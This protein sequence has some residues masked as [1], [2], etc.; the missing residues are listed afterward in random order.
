[1]VSMANAAGWVTAQVGETPLFSGPPG[2]VKTE[3]AKAFIRWAGRRPFC[4][5][6]SIIAA[7]AVGG[8]PGVVEVDGKRYCEM[9]PLDWAM[10]THEQPS[11]LIIDEL[12]TSPPPVQAAMLRIICERKIGNFDLPAD[13]WIIS[14][15]NPP[16]CAANGFELEPPMANRLGHYTWK[17][18]WD[19]VMAG[20][21]NGL[22]FPDL[23]YPKVPENWMDYQPA[24]GNLCAA[25]RER[26][27]ELFEPATDSSGNMK[28]SDSE[29]G[30]A[31]GTARSWTALQKVWSGLEAVGLGDEEKFE[32]GA[33]YV[34]VDSAAEFVTYCK[35]L[36][37]PDPEAWLTRFHDDP[38]ADFTPLDRPDLTIAF[39]GSLEYAVREN[40]TK[41]RW[42]A[43]M[44]LLNNLVTKPGQKV[45]VHEAARALHGNDRDG[46][47]IVKDNYTMPA[48]LGQELQSL[49]RARL[50]VKDRS[51][52]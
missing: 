8:Y 28:L 12:T 40:N 27:P 29:Q 43:A 36:D 11:A 31:Y 1:M 2:S 23:E 35:E 14:M 42:E 37:L 24:I 6:G 21:R 16:G 30:G 33:A 32:A 39:L 46:N 49:L 44:A 48:Q 34:G 51:Q 3:V 10:M 38:T 5:I 50:N 13:L 22:N 17:T 9:M 18:P 4:L 45:L 15:C 41:G 7:P 25:F 26:K 47:K 19:T 52:N 20:W